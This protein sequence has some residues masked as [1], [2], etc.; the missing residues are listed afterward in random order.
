MSDTTIH[1]LLAVLLSIT[2][3]TVLV[4]AAVVVIAVALHQCRSHLTL[5][6]FAIKDEVGSLVKALKVFEVIKN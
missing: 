1:I 3:F 6:E 5:F 4:F 2:V